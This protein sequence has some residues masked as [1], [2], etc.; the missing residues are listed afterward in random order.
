[1]GVKMAKGTTG[2]RRGQGR[3]GTHD[4]YD[5]RV[6]P[7][8]HPNLFRD[9]SIIKY[10][11]DSYIEQ[12]IDVYTKAT[13]E[14][15]NQTDADRYAALFWANE[16]DRYIKVTQGNQPGSLVVEDTR[17]GEAS[18]YEGISREMARREYAYERLLFMKYEKTG[19]YADRK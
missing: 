8:S 13:F 9:G 3:S 6:T 14:P 1:M 12:R 18:Y 4:L 7:D 5:P 19:I 2:G 10:R 15:G 17:G 16:N 11:Y